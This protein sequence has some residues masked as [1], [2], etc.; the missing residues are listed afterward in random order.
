[1]LVRE[2][3]LAVE[4]TGMTKPA[5]SGSSS[6]PVLDSIVACDLREEL[7]L[8]HTAGGGLVHAEAVDTGGQ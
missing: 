4:M 5:I 3:K 7:T 6:N 2:R 8:R 1:M